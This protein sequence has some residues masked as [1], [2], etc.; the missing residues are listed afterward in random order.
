[1][2]IAKNFMEVPPLERGKDRPTK[3][4]DHQ[5]YFLEIFFEYIVK[6]MKLLNR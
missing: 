4:E 1:M 6:K 5:Y 3:K 2:L